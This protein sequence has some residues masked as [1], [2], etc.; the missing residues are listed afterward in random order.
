MQKVRT[1]QTGSL[2][3]NSEFQLI[4][5]RNEL[6]FSE[7]FEVRSEKSEDSIILEI[8]GN[9]I[10]IPEHIKNEIITFG[11]CFWKIAREKVQSP[12]K[13]RK[14]QKGDLFF[15][16]GMIGKKKIS[17][18]FK[19]EKLSI[20]AKQKIWLFCDEKDNILGVLPFR[21]DRRFVT[22]DDNNLVL[23]V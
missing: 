16:I 3:F 19:D 1:A 7:R 18:F 4:I 8:V 12:L 9:E 15:P 6:I 13:L 21:Q 2:F 14:K 10:V 5:N 23:Q 22:D 17:K 11:N 20:L